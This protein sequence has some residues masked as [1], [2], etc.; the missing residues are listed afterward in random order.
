M[1]GSWEAPT[2]VASPYVPAA[3]TRTRLPSGFERHMG[4]RFA[5][6]WTPGLGA[7]MTKAGGPARWFERQLGSTYD[8]RWFTTSRT[9]W[10][11]LGKSPEALW[12]DHTSGQRQLWEVVGDYGRWTLVRRIRGQR[13]VL[14]SMTEFWEDHL[15]VP[16]AAEGQA[17]FRTAYGVGIRARALGT[18][19]GLLRFATTH[20]AMG[21]YLNNATSRA[22]AP[23]E[24]L[25]RE[26]LECHTVGAG[27]FSEDDVKDAARVLTGYRVDVWKTWHVGYDELSHALGAVRVLGFR[28]SNLL[29]DGRPVATRLLRYLARHPLTARRIAHKLAVRFVS[30]KPSS[31]LVDRLARVYL[32]NGTKIRPVLRALVA[33]TE[34]RS[35]AAR[36]VRTPEQDVVA[37][38]RVLRIRLRKPQ[39]ASAAGNAILYQAESL[40]LRPFGWPRPDGRPDTA[41]AYSSTARMLASF[42][43]H[44]NLA[45][46]WWPRGDIT[47]QEPA[48]WLPQPRIRFDKL[49]DH[50]SRVLLGRRS[51]A[52]LL[53]ACCEAT[54]VE[55]ATTVDADHS[56]VRWHMPRLLS[57]VLDTPAHMTR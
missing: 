16:T 52:R 1:G 47:Y 13:Q 25:A 55:P 21:V 18:F 32:A 54:G 27:A 12:E 49:V 14:E 10:P 30:D 51:T 17:L 29:P 23:N 50:L 5:Y 19:E 48:S 35:A 8:D 46:G 39:T 11:S 7:Q 53:Q 24:D 57:C 22:A 33:S 42:T 36:K 45:G 2:A 9:W 37:S 3:Y 15:H 6:G 31:A 40:G 56:L 28:D 38:Y 20:P 4:N 44:F 26:L 43:T 34:F 41:A